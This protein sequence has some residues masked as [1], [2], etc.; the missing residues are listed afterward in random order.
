MEIHL[1]EVLANTRRMAEITAHPSGRPLEQVERDIDRD[2]FL[3]AAFPLPVTRGPWQPPPSR[4]RRRA[5][6]RLEASHGPLAMA[7]P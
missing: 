2:Y 5:G 3:T 6:H 4:T 1:R 7:S